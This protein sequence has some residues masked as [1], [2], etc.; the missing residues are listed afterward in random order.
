MGCQS[1]GVRSSMLSWYRKTPRGMESR[2]MRSCAHRVTS[3][4]AAWRGVWL[5]TCQPLRMRLRLSM[6]SRMRPRGKRR[7]LYRRGAAP[8]QILPFVL[9]SQA[10]DPRRRIALQAG[11][12]CLSHVEDPRTAKSP[13]LC[14][15]SWRAIKV[16]SERHDLWQSGDK[17]LPV[18]VDPTR[19]AVELR[20]TLQVLVQPSLAVPAD[21]LMCHSR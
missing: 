8:A 19:N 1:G 13:P 17:P 5:R 11:E 21:L 9:T 16:K 12:A 14:L 20:P 15:R 18:Q 7:V 10:S 6:V 4:C 2:L 3:Q